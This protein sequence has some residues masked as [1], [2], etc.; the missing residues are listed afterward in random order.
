MTTY[1]F[2]LDLGRCIGCQACVAACKTGN[3]LPVGMQYIQISEQTRGIFP[4]LAGSFRN[5][6]CYHCTDAACVAVCPS[7]ALY[8]EDGL[9]R[10]DRNMCIR[11]GRCV[12]ICPYDVPVRAEDRRSSKCD[13][14]AAAVEAGGSPWCVQTCPNHALMYGERDE[15]LA[16][17]RTRLATLKLRYPNAQIYGEQE[18][19]G[20]GVIMVLP[21][22]SDKLELPQVSELSTVL[23]DWRQRRRLVP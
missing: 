18:F 13:G 11:C 2:L 3:E 4:N 8:K 10:L 19:G 20:L 7:G 14:C 1:A 23:D 5:H 21:D 16:E 22:S 9:T 6:R 15:I 17:A 12:E